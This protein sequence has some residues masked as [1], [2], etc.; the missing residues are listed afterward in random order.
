MKREKKIHHQARWIGGTEGW[1][2]SDCYLTTYSV[3]MSELWERVT[4]RNCLKA[5]RAG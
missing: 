1:G 5:R 4:C 3:E 2:V